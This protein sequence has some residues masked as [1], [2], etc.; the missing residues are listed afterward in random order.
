MDVA[1]YANGCTRMESFVPATIQGPAV[2]RTGFKYVGECKDSADR[3][4]LLRFEF[5]VEESYMLEFG[6]GYVRFYTDRAQVAGLGVVAVQRREHPP[7][8][9]A[10]W[11]RALASTTASPRRRATR[12]RMRPIGT[13]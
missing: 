7:T 4:W 13:R 8:P 12:R 5:S 11:L 1:K 3:A 9:W 6:D 10:T 2:A